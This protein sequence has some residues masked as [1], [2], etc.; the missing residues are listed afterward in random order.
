[1]NYK[2]EDQLKKAKQLLVRRAISADDLRTEA[3][4]KHHI[5]LIPV[6][7]VENILQMVLTGE[8]EAFYQ[9]Q[10]EVGHP[11]YI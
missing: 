10:K 1:M 6:S 4:R 9:K 7:D 3:V 2:M 11:H 5:A 8:F